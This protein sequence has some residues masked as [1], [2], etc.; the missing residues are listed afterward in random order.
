MKRLL[1]A[2]LVALAGCAQLPH[3][4]P[5]RPSMKTP[6]AAVTIAGLAGEVEQPGTPVTVSHWWQ[7]FGQP[8]LDRLI[9]SALKEQPD[10][11]AARARLRIAGQA[12]RLA[13]LDSQVHYSTDASVVREHLSENGLFPPPIGGSSFTQTDLTQNLSYSLDWWDKN[14]SLIRAAGNETQAARQEQAAVELALAS[15]VADTYFAWADTD[16]SLAV[17]RTLQRRHRQERDLLRTRFDLGLD[18]AQPSIDARRKL[19]QDEDGIRQLEY[20][21]RSLRYRMSALIGSDP[22]HAM[23]LPAPSLEARLPALPATLPLGW[24]AMRPDVAALRSRVEA[25]ADRSS[26][27][28]A[29]FY[30]NV[31]LSLMVGLETLD[32]GKLLRAGSISATAGPAI[33]LPIF[34]TSTLRAK[35]GLREAD[36]AA[37]VAA[38][39]GA[40][41]DAAR[42]SADAYALVASLE[43]RGKAQGEA[44]KE[45][46]RMRAL[47]EQRDRLGLAGPLDTLEADSA[48]LGQSMNEIAI[49]AARLRAR[50]ALF[51]ALGGDATTK[52]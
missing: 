11:A 18:S 8:E 34:N 32:L 22:D 24:L 44:L 26:A 5:P 9:E 30:P 21:D 14:R 13:R 28:K 43:R 25:A 4:L 16:A 38:Y 40:I 7:A 23:D 39:N 49:Q 27:A 6:E 3:D 52:D 2:M 35:L 41:L 48:V 29:D 37:A 36:Y 42:Q 10:I 20:L 19:D 51:E 15:A 1:S 17:A 45:T 47:A 50:V 12:E 33:H 46:E 31:D